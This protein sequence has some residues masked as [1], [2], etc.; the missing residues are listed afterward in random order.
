M[1]FLLFPFLIFCFALGNCRAQHSLEKKKEDFYFPK[2][3]KKSTTYK[4]PP[5]TVRL[6][7]SIFIDAN[8][9]TNLMYLEFYE[10][11]ESFWTLSVSDSLKKISKF[12]VEKVYMTEHFESLP[13]DSTLFKKIS[14]N[15]YSQAG[16]IN[17]ETYFSY[18]KYYYFP[19]V[20]IS[21]VQAELYCKWRTDLVNLM[22]S[23]ISKN[24]EQRNKFP[25]KFVYRLP[26][27]AEFEL[28]QLKFGFSKAKVKR[29]NQFPVFPVINNKKSDYSTANFFEHNISEYTLDADPFG[30]NWR[31]ETD[32]PVINDY[33]GFRCVCEIFD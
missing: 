26:T 17:M 11:V 21:K 3:I 15:F 28:A 29:D 25:Y 4:F 32:F 12:G 5:G 33:T 9:V 20:N 7:D 31:N 19:I 13:T 14:P 8:P 23:I 10:S 24:K 22:L 6:N 27:Q 1:R 16:N 18:T 30:N 2:T